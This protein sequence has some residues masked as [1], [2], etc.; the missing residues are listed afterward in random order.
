MYAPQ[1]YFHLLSCTVAQPAV[2]CVV[3]PAAPG[4]VETTDGWEVF[5]LICIPSDV[6]ISHGHAHVC[7][8][9]VYLICDA[10]VKSVEPN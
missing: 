1:G 9:Y 7:L 8:A 10:T 3:C 2:H 6:L 4:D 5:L